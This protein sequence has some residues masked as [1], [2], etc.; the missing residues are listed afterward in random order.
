[1]GGVHPS[2]IQQLHQWDC[3]ALKEHHSGPT[4]VTPHKQIP[5]STSRIS[6]IFYSFT[7]FLFRHVGFWGKIQSLGKP[8]LNWDFQALW[9]KLCFSSASP[10]MFAF[11]HK[12]HPKQL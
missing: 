8:H 12:P 11:K 4:V 10:N 2:S 7:Y 1:M 3:K 6:I 5:N 9:G